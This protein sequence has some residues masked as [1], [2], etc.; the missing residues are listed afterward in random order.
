MA[1]ED[2]E[3]GV[4]FHADIDE[5]KHKLSEAGE[6]LHASF[7]KL[8]GVF[9]LVE[10]SFAA[11]LV[12]MGGGEVFEHAIEVTS[13]IVDKTRDLSEALG[14]AADEAMAIDNAMQ[15]VG[16]STADYEQTLRRLE[17]RLNANKE[18][19]E[20]Y[21]IETRDANGQLLGTREILKNTLDVLE[22]TKVGADRN[23]VA[24]QLMGRGAGDVSKLMRAMKVD[25][26][27]VAEDDRAL[28][29]TVTE[30]GIAMRDKYR[31]AMV[32][33]NDVLEALWNKIGQSVMPVLTEMAEW[34]ASTGPDAVSL[35]TEAVAAVGEVFGI[36]W[37]AVDLV[38]NVFVGLASWLK[39]LYGL[40]GEYEE[41]ITGVTSALQLLTNM[42]KVVE[43]AF[44]A[45]KTIIS[46]V[47]QVVLGLGQAVADVEE[48]IV[49][50]VLHP[51][52]AL[53][54]L[55]KGFAKAKLDAEQA[56]TGIIDSWEEMGNKVDEIASRTGAT[57]GPAAKPQSGDA[58]AK[59]KPDPGAR[60]A[61][62]AVEKANQDAIL[63]LLKEYAAEDQAVLDR[64]YELGLLSDQQYY[65]RKIA[66]E[67]KSIDAAIAAKQAELAAN[68]DSAKGASKEADR[69][70]LKAKAI[71][72]E[73]ELKVLEAQ[74][75]QAVIKNTGA[76]LD[77]QQ[78][79]NDALDTNEIDRTKA[80]ADS[81]IAIEAAQLAV[82][83]QLGML[84]AK[85]ALQIQTEQ[86]NR[87]YQ[88]TAEMLTRKRILIHGQ[89]DAQIQ[90]R[91]DIDKQ[92]E[93]AEQAHQ[94]KLTQIVGQA[95]QARL[96]YAVDLQN[97]I[98]M[99]STTFLEKMMHNVHSFSSAMRSLGQ[100]IANT[101]VHVGAQMVVNWVKDQNLM[102]IATLAGNATR[103]A[104]DWW[105]AAE[106]VAATA[107]TAIKKI[108][109]LAWSVAA[110]VYDA[111]AGIPY[112]GPFIAPVAAVAAAITV[113]SF[114]GKIASAEGGWW[115]VPGDTVA[116]IHKD[117]MVMPAPLASSMRE[118]IEGGGGAGGGDV[119]IH[120]TPLKGG[121]FMVHQDE[122]VRAYDAARKGRRT[123]P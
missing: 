75:A 14:V 33:V 64:S 105:A 107:W 43:I 81:A 31:S 2:H 92:A 52:E 66:L 99:A 106:S 93:A 90:A 68:I 74:R 38:I 85:Q 84:S 76:M 23:T 19:F 65:D 117:E 51:T 102:T 24:M 77:A 123:K 122:L 1:Q 40:N 101:F 87:S 5:F 9:G 121:F 58:S 55:S 39:K 32:D 28:G 4:G 30:T 109:A 91:A 97:G 108:A 104:S 16:G 35:M 70:N 3:V 44:E 18:A 36:L 67:Q 110:E 69:L 46:T 103:V 115:Q 95:D 34:F 11:L 42:V 29:L 41:S 62:L 80:R 47:I 8:E 50:A 48:A 59:P 89:D 60:A 17:M 113:G 63:A 86:E 53:G 21:G 13:E 120:G 98:E 20:L 112:V 56:A 7:E 119:H 57:K 71:L 6:H 100:S 73:G 45:L 37:D 12:V 118:V 111:L 15:M 72:L 94:L 10:K 26:E 22:K 82:Q 88:A 83:V 54:I 78:K 49:D 116:A 27:K 114:A 61:A 96:Q 25:L 79:L